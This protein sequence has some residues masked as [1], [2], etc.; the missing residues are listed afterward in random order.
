M[1]D[2]F[3]TDHLL[4][5][6]VGFAVPLLQYTDSLFLFQRVP[7]WNL[8]RLNLQICHKVFSDHFSNQQCTFY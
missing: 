5:P 2:L 7:I 3:L 1:L 6:F 4:L 8:I